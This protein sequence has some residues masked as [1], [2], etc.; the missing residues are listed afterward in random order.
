MLS[1]TNVSE[2]ISKVASTTNF[3]T[4]H[5]YQIQGLTDFIYSNVNTDISTD[6]RISLGSLILCKIISLGRESYEDDYQTKIFI[7]Q[8]INRINNVRE[9]INDILDDYDNWNNDYFD[10]SLQCEIDKIEILKSKSD[11]ISI[12]ILMKSFDINDR[13]LEYKKVIALNENYLT[14][15]RTCFLY[16]LENKELLTLSQKIYVEQ[17]VMCNFDEDEYKSYLA[18]LSS[19]KYYILSSSRLKDFYSN[20]LLLLNGRMEY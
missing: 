20:F 10:S 14:S 15:N 2:Y 8:I 13:Y 16:P 9:T 7:Y 12:F 4:L 19:L 11:I 6:F 5:I 18:F 3:Y 17:D 1:I